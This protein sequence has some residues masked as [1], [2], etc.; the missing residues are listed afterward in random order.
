M[1]IFSSLYKQHYYTKFVALP[2][3]L[4]QSKHKTTT[5]NLIH[6]TSERSTVHVP[7]VQQKSNGLKFS[8][9]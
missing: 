3:V 7:S 6:N 9:S 2:S 5:R 4:Q 1:V 8:K